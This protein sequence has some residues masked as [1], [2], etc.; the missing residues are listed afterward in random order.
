L[1]KYILKRGDE[2][3]EVLEGREERRDKLIAAGYEWV[4]KP[5]ESDPDRRPNES[6]AP[7]TRAPLLPSKSSSAGGGPKTN[8]EES[9]ARST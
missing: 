4:N 9:H 6:D 1:R 7:N 5:V 3:V 2:T 8:K